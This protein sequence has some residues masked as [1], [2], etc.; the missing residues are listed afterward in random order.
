MSTTSISG[1]ACGAQP[2][3][4]AIDV[5]AE[6]MAK[7]LLNWTNRRAERTMPSHERVALLIDNEKH[8][9]NRAIGSPLSR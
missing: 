7:S 5:V 6:K 8:T 1:Q 3:R 9:V 2:H 4:P